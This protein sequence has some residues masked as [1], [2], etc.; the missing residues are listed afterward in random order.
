MSVNHTVDGICV[1]MCSAGDPAALHMH[2]MAEGRGG[3]EGGFEGG[4]GVAGSSHR[5]IND[6]AMGTTIRTAML[7]P[8]QLK[9]L[10]LM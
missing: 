2:M 9:S 10:L 1:I 8:T 6:P 5:N 7:L 3:R 4:L